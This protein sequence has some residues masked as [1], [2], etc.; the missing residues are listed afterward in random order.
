MGFD[1]RIIVKLEVEE[2]YEFDIHKPI[3]FHVNLN[4]N[5]FLIKLELIK[6]MYRHDRNDNCFYM[7]ADDAFNLTVLFKAFEV[8]DGMLKVGTARIMPRC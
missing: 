2:G 6:N 1:R 7:Q 3:I 8:N 5:I 4:D